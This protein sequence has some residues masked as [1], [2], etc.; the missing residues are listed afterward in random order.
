MVLPRPERLRSVRFDGDRAYAITFEQTDPLFTIDLGE[1]AAPVQA[2]EL[3]IPGWVFHMHPQGDRVL[4]LGFDDGNAAGSL[5]VSLFDVSD[6]ESP[7]L[8][9]RVNFGGDYGWLAEDQDRIHKAFNI[10]DEENLILVP[11]S[12]LGRPCTK[13][14]SSP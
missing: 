7:G 6:L 9:S 2:R 11:F 14:R 5:T 3:E 13:A 10:L 12:G 1:P 8:L 4:G